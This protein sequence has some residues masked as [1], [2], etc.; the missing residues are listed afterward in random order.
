MEHQKE[1]IKAD[2]TKKM[3]EYKKQQTGNEYR[4]FG[5]TMV[6]LEQLHYNV[7]EDTC[8][9]LTASRA[10]KYGQKKVS[11]TQWL[12]HKDVEEFW[13]GH[14]INM[15]DE[16]L[17][18]CSE[19]A[20]QIF[21]GN[22]VQSDNGYKVCPG[23]PIVVGLPK[24]DTEIEEEHH[25]PSDISDLESAFDNGECFLADHKFICEEDLDLLTDKMCMAIGDYDVCDAD[26]HRLFH[27]EQVVLEDGYKIVADFDR[28]GYDSLCREYGG[29]EKCLDD[30]FDLYEA[31]HDC[32]M[33]DGNWLCQD[34]IVYFWKEGCVELYG[35]RLCGHTMMDIVLQQCATIDGTQICP[36]AVGTKK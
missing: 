18:L 12:C 8:M 31:P 16:S 22:C 26:L 24:I 35:Q 21:L 2:F 29:E 1:A 33:F 19:K 10:N 5:Q 13:S 25:S 14:C 11:D 23:A 28:P 17:E 30:I 9:Q 3:I 15:M 6:S 36:T 27:G 34:E 32:V 7:K 4:L 20:I